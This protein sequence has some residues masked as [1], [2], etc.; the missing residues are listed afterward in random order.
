MT[1]RHATSPGPRYR[2]QPGTAQ[3]GHRR[4]G[5]HSTATTAARLAG[6]FRVRTTTGEDACVAT[7]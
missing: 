1:N 5:A 4:A 3:S 2:C 6:R 7:T